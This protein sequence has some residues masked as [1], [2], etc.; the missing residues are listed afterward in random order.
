MINSCRTWLIFSILTFPYSHLNGIYLSTMSVKISIIPLG[1]YGITAIVA[2]PQQNA[3]S[4]LDIATLVFVF[5]YAA[6]IL[7]FL[8]I[9]VFKGVRSI[10]L[11]QV[12]HRDFYKGCKIAQ[13]INKCFTHLSIK[14]LWS[15]AIYNIMDSHE[16]KCHFSF[17]KETM[18][19]K[20]HIFVIV[21]SMYTKML[22][23]IFCSTIPPTHWRQ[24]SSLEQFEVHFNKQTLAKVFI[25]PLKILLA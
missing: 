5:F 22:N 13:I 2:Q 17:R 21:W 15:M 6:P 12:P 7:G 18:C 10:Y 20:S 8:Q 24:A 14:D 4:I 3:Q 1:A 9:R 11:S 23:Q 19:D 25:F 16:R